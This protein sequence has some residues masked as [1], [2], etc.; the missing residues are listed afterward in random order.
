MARKRAIDSIGEILSGRRIFIVAGYAYG[1]YGINSLSAIA[2]S[3][4]ADAFLGG[5]AFLF[6]SL[7]RNSIRILIWEDDGYY[8][9]ERRSVSR[10]FRW[11]MKEDEECIKDRDAKDATHLLLS[12]QLFL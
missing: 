6:C 1:R 2:M 10:S 7:S 8:L 11:P 12:N 9:I 3:C 5:A 4:D